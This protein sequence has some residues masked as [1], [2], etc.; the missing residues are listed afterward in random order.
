MNAP[1]A[2]VTLTT[3][4]NAFRNRLVAKTIKLQSC[5]AA[6]GPIDRRACEIAMV[7]YLRE[8]FGSG[9][10]RMDGSRAYSTLD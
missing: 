2:G 1:A 7:V 4:G 5:G 6:E 3:A 9:S 8:R 10:V